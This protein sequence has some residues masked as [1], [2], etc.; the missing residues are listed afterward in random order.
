MLKFDRKYKA[1]PVVM[2]T[3]KSQEGDV[4]LDM[5]SGLIFM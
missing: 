5:R 3:A 4:K 2:L 1:I